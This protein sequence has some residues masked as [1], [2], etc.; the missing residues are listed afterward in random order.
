MNDQANAILA[1]IQ[2]ATNTKVASDLQGRNETRVDETG[3]NKNG[4]IIFE[5]QI[6]NR[7]EA[8][9][10]MTERE[11]T[12]RGTA[13]FDVQ[14][15]VQDQIAAN[16]ARLVLRRNILWAINARI[17]GSLRDVL[18]G[19]RETA[20][21]T[22]S[23]DNWNEFIADVSVAESA[24][25]YADDLGY[26][27]YGSR[28]SKARAL[29]SVAQ[30]WYDLADKDAR[31][32]RAKLD[33]PSLI[34]MIHAPQQFDKS[35]ADKMAMAVRLSMEDEFTEEEIAESEKFA[36]TKAHNDHLNRNAMNKEVGPVLE[37]LYL[38]AK[39]GM[40][41]EP[42]HF[43]QLPVE[44]QASLIE[45][46]QRSAKKLPMQLAKMNSVDTIELAMAVPQLK[47]LG[48]KLDEVLNSDKYA[49]VGV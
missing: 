37:R 32:S 43:W 22:G 49:G 42:V 1:S 5:G 29:I 41:A 28:I 16:H 34:E 35:V 4:N 47:R 2:A 33:A 45:A 11:I 27:H 24:S 10:I 38:V 30:N 6:V 26:A 14:D 15:L 36:V 13:L 7:T 17:I 20:I 23:V 3:M 48:K 39:D 21:Q 25:Q 46:V 12:A 44:T 8:Q 40:D 9:R 19:M 18:F 31:A